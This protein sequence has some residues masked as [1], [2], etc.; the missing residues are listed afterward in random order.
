MIMVNASCVIAVQ[1][2]L[3]LYDMK[4]I[5][6]VRYF[7]SSQGEIQQSE[8]ITS[9]VSRS[10]ALAEILS[11]IQESYPGERVDIKSAVFLRKERG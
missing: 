1:Q 6:D 9:D 2:T 7:V 3:S 11:Q 10:E 8:F 4:K 5:Y